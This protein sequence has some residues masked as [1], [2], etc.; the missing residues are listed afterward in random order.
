LAALKD[1][2]QVLPCFI[3][4]K[5]QL[6]NNPYYS[7]ACVEFM[8]G[9]LADLQRQLQTHNAKL[10]FFYGIA[11]DIVER[12]LTTLPIK[13][14]FMNRDYTPFSL[15]RDQKIAD[16]C[17]NYA[18]NF[19]KYDDAL[20]N[21]P[22]AITKADGTPYV[23]FSQFLRKAR[24]VPVSVPQANR[25]HNYY[26]QP[27]SFALPTIPSSILITPNPHLALQGGRQEA[28]QLLKKIIHLKDYAEVRNFPA[29]SGTSQLSAHNKFGTLSIRE[30]FQA[31]VKEY[32][33]AHGLISELYWRDFFTHIGCHFPRV[34][35][36]AFRAQYDALGWVKNTE[37]F[38]RWCEGNTGFPIVDAGMRELN[39]TGYM[40]N[41]VRMIV[42]S[43]LVK[44]LHLDWRWGE[45]YFAQQLI[46][47]DPAVNN[48]NWQWIASTGCDAQP[49]FRIFNP[50][51]QQKKFDSECEYIKQ[52]VPELRLLSAKAIHHLVDSDFPRPA[53]YPLPIINHSEESKVSLK[54]YRTLQR[55]N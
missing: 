4:D 36:N 7:N 14:V 5:R 34:F 26:T 51:L 25:Q 23:V 41:R 9:C 49:Y 54:M 46:D 40:H 16:V 29:K 53:S 28:K 18:V 44:D 12:L 22:E 33:E 2:D 3:F 27:I 10:Y 17:K 37:L 55:K 19:E 24:L 6:E 31:V 20:L 11:E 39:I 47:Y 32:G 38:K 35:G 21:E 42:G 52:W 1:A 15:N 45:R 30:F 50:W 43:F 48:G 13:A 8:L